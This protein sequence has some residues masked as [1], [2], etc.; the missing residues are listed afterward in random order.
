[1]SPKEDESEIAGIDEFSLELLKLDVNASALS[2][3]QSSLMA[4]IDAVGRDDQ[5]KQ[6]ESELVLPSDLD[7]MLN[8]LGPV[9][10]DAG[11]VIEWQSLTDDQL[12]LLE[13]LDTPAKDRAAGMLETWNANQKRF[14]A[15]KT[16]KSAKADKKQREI[17]AY[18][19]GPGRLA[20]NEY[21]KTL[22]AAKI[23]D[24]QGRTVRSYGTP[25]DEAKLARRREQKRLTA[26]TARAK[27]KAK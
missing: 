12:L 26:A 5:G 3:L 22:Y 21:K 7:R 10:Q 13:A 8:E 14:A 23:E 15:T 11:L 19:A 1:M 25:D 24:T 27:A 20:Y 2:P 9:N 6:T 18:R 4:Q 16:I 17:E